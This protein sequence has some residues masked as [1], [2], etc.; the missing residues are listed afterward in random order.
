VRGI[1]RFDWSQK[2]PEK[3][4]IKPPPAASVYD[5]VSD[6]TARLALCVFLIFFQSSTNSA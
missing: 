3:A 6:G 5:G 2:A 4:P 1:A